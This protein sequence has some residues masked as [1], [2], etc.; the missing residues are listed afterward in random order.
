MIIQNRWVIIHRCLLLLVI[1]TLRWSSAL[2]FQHLPEG[3]SVTSSS[4]IGR[5]I[6]KSKRKI[7]RKAANN[8]TPSRRRL[9]A[10]ALIGIGSALLSPPQQAAA[11]PAETRDDSTIS[12]PSALSLFDDLIPSSLMRCGAPSTNATL[13]AEVVERIE[14]TALNLEHYGLKS[15]SSVTGATNSSQN[16]AISP[17]L[18]GNWR[19]VYSNAPEITSLASKLPVGFCL[20]P[21]YQPI[22]TDLGLFENM[23]P[24]I[25]LGLAKIQIRVVG[26]IKVA[27]QGSLNSIG[28]VNSNNNR[29]NV[30]FDAI[31]FELQELFGKRGASAKNEAWFQKTLTPRQKTQQPHHAQNTEAD[32]TLSGEQVITVE[33]RLP[34]NDITYLDPMIRIVRG[35]DGSLFIFRKEE[36]GSTNMLSAE[37]RERLLQKTTTA[38]QGDNVVDVGIGVAEKSKSPELQFLFQERRARKE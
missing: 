21:T 34:A 12:S 5:K 25:L 26:T 1:A 4:F 11:T 28:V 38:K 27:K 9:V 15:S 33:A 20:G 10:G 8:I 31:I 22:D 29:V 19:L 35:G 18:S 17:L 6:E 36:D 32:E 37:E 2:S 13:P 23:S 24:V 30:N 3:R 16:N 7:T 14:S